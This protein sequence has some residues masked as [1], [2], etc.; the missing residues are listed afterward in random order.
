MYKIGT[1]I[2][3]GEYKLINNDLQGLPAYMDVSSDA[4]GSIES[5]I[6]NDNFNGQKYITIQSGQYLQ[7]KGCYAQEISSSSDQASQLQIQSSQQ[8]ESTPTN[9]QETNLKTV[10]GQYGG[11]VSIPDNW[12]AAPVQ[13]YGG[14]ATTYVWLD[15]TDSD[16]KLVLYMTMGFADTDSY[17]PQGATISRISATKIAYVIDTSEKYPD[18]GLIEVGGQSE[19]AGDVIS[20]AQGTYYQE[21]MIANLYLPFSQPALAK[22]IF[23]SINGWVSSPQ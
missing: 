20:G 9:A 14:P 12:V 11:T 19:P 5:I 1:D 10:T 13:N 23:D 7:F 16:K 22:Q 4:S 21:A 2:P 8:D 15:P 6:T 17:I 3:A 18:T